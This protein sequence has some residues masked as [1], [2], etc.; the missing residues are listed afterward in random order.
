[1]SDRCYTS[2]RQHLPIPMA[3]LQL[4]FVS[5]TGDPVDCA[6][7]LHSPSGT[8]IP[9]KVSVCLS[10]SFSPTIHTP[11]ATP[12][13]QPNEIGASTTS[14]KTGKPPLSVVGD[15]PVSHCARYRYYPGAVWRCALCTWEL[16]NLSESQGFYSLTSHYFKSHYVD[17]NSI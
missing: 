4:S 12:A 15:G 8:A 11:G 16:S 3:A 6:E 1:M 5:V 17:V 13:K 9:T 7:V 14:T 10:S 2:T